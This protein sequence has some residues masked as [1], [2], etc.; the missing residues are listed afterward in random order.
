MQC[1]Y[2]IIFRV[3]I[4]NTDSASF[5]YLGW[6]FYLP[7]IIWEWMETYNNNN[8]NCIERPHVHHNLSDD[9]LEI[10]NQ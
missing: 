10:I 4:A 9:E 1:E 8:I 3:L 7:S 2:V 6:R 5:N